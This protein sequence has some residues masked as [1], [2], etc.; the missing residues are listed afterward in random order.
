MIW[1]AVIERSQ[2]SR[3]LLAYSSPCR[4]RKK[5]Q[6]TGCLARLLGYSVF[7]QITGSRDENAPKTKD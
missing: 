7:E 5:R 6:N 1:S 2:K 3:V 4:N